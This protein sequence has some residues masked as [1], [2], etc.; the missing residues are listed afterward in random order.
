MVRGGKFFMS[1][2][3]EL[4][5]MLSNMDNPED[6]SFPNVVAGNLV[7]SWFQQDVPYSQRIL[8]KYEYLT[9]ELE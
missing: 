3:P 5:F 6:Y 7:E 8:N 1:R 2:R 4:D 9:F